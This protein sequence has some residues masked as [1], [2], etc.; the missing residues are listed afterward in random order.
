VT[1]D[2]R[3]WADWRYVPVLKGTKD[4]SHSPVYTRFLTTS[5]KGQLLEI[6]FTS[7]L[8]LRARVKAKIDH[9]MDDRWH[10]EE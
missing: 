8:N 7:N 5:Y 1:I 10:L 6:T 3:K 9:I 4:Y 2:G